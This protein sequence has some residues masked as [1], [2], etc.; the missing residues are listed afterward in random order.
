MVSPSPIPTLIVRNASVVECV[1][2]LATAS[3]SSA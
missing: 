3:M 2:A 1:H